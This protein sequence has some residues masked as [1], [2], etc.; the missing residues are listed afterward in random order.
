MEEHSVLR[1]NEKDMSDLRVHQENSLAIPRVK[2]KVVGWLVPLLLF[3]SLLFS[4][5]SFAY[6]SGFTKISYSDPSITYTGSWY[7]LSP[8]TIMYTSN[9]GDSAQFQINST[10]VDVIFRRD[11]DNGIVQILVDGIVHGTYD[12]AG[13]ADISDN[14]YYSVTG[15]SPG[16]HTIKIVNYKASGGTYIRLFGYAVGNSSPIT[17]V[18]TATTGNA[19]VTLTWPAVNGATGYNIKRSTTAG[20]PYTTIASNVYGSPYTDTTVTN[21]TKYYYVVTA[22][23]SSGE[24]GNSNEASATPQGTVTPP[25]GNNRAL[26]VITLVSGLEKEYDLSMTEV[27]SFTTWY[28]AR[29]AGTGAEVYTINKSFN[30]ASFLTRK[31][32]IAFNKIELYEVNEYTPTP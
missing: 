30:K 2:V 20:G 25:A 14:F 27:N 5:P 26:L 21:G 23:N 12:A 16:T 10:A 3:M 7:D 13:P 4:I 19:Q 15:L 8:G 32:N 31:D 1:G 11:T 6:T 17:P 24:S 9:L 29:A 18:L 22:L 28:A